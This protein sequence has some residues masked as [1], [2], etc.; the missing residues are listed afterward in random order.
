MPAQT[1]AYP[2]P[3]RLSHSVMELGRIF[4]EVSSGYLLQ[5][6]L[7]ALPRGD[8]HSVMT[9]PGYMGADGSMAS[10]RKFLDRQGYT[11]MPWGQG[12]NVPDAGMNNMEQALEFRRAME[13]TLAQTLKT[14]MRRTGRRVS[15][16][17]WS[18]G[19][20]YATGLAHRYPDLVRQVVTMGT[21]FGDPRAT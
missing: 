1:L 9:L 15:L 18:L 12:R 8:G 6:L 16:V 2:A 19:G 21:P 10:L 17:G 7:K 5:P 14:E 13:E 4:L 3:P 20:L 11:G